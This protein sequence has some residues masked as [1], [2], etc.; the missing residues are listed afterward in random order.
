MQRVFVCSPF[1][2]DVEAN[3]KYAQDAMLNCLAR[4]EAPYVPHLLYTQVLNE[5]DPEGRNLGLLVAKTFL[6]VCDKLIV[7][8]DRGISAGMRAEIDHAENMGKEVEYRH[9]Y[10]RG[11]P[12]ENN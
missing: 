4:G 10:R 3:V 5:D 9:L 2:G 7:Y 8:N 6:E 12:D 11:V 1:R